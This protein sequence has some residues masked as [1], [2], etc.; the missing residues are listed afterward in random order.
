MEKDK[1]R[2][3]VKE[4]LNLYN[5]FSTTESH[6]FSK[7]DHDTMTGFSEGLR[8][9]SFVK[10]LSN[11]KSD[12]TFVVLEYGI[13]GT[14]KL[15]DISKQNRLKFNAPNEKIR[16]AI[17]GY[18]ELVI[19]ILAS[20]EVRDL[21]N[22]FLKALSDKDHWLTKAISKFLELA[23]KNLIWHYQDDKGNKYLCSVKISDA[24]NVFIFKDSYKISDRRRQIS[25]LKKLLA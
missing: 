3:G 5:V 13:E 25:A 12:L 10:D 14:Y 1:E 15:T 9:M 16:N 18:E 23:M 6:S 21:M 24:G 8:N 2:L 7:K 17:S 22:T 20:K 11:I 4:D 19:K